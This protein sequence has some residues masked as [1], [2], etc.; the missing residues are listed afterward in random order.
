MKHATSRMLFAYWDAL[1]GER[2][3]PD[4]GDVEPGELRHILADTFILSREADHRPRFRLAGTRIAALFGR[5][6]K[7]TAFAR[8]WGAQETSDCERLVDLVTGDGVGVL[9][10]LVGTNEN[11]SELPI[12]LLL[13]PLRHRGR[14]DLRLIGVAS[15]ASV[16]SWAGLVPLARLTTRSVRI[17]EPLREAER[18]SADETGAFAASRRRLLV[19]HEGGLA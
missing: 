17:I 9:A 13:L 6:L 15:P 1:R 11:G 18:H 19:V 4:R 14:T 10:G 7:G 16:P 5:D 8:L 3:A 2:A 12:E